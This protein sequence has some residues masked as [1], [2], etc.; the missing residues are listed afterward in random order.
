M[1]Q[2]LPFTAPTPRR[3]SRP[4]RAPLARRCAGRR[5]GARA[6]A[7]RRGARA[8]SRDQD[9]LLGTIL[10]VNGLIS[11]RRR[12]AERCRE[13]SGHR[14]DRP[15]RQ[16]AGPRRC[17]DGVD[18]YR[19]LE[20]E[21]VPWRHY[22][23]HAGGR[24]RATRRTAEAAMAAC[25]GGAEPGGAGARPRRRRSAGRSPAHFAGRLRDDARDALPGGLQLPLAD[26]PTRPTAGASSAALAALAGGVALAPLAGA[27]ARA[28]LGA[29]SPTSRPWRCGWWRS[30]PGCGGGRG[31]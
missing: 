15:R 6:R 16:P 20:L 18:P 28:R 27:A 11:R 22:R 29:R 13:Q 14:A 7:A 23:R 30:S 3:P 5:R 21:A 19:C 12:S 4:R 26:E 25:G 9:T 1:A 2:V 24:D 31:R 10:V 17:C 8:S